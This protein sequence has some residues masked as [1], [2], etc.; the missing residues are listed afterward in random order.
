MSKSEHQQQ[1][2]SHRKRD[3]VFSIVGGILVTVQLF[4]SMLLVFSL[5]KLNILQAWQ[6]A[7][8]IIILAL[9]LAY[10]VFELVFR[11]R[12]KTFG[13]VASCILAALIAGGC[14]YAYTYIQQAN[15]FISEITTVREET[16]M[17]EVRI[18]KD[19][20]I[21]DIKELKDQP[22]GFLKTSPNLDSI[23]TTLKDQLGS[24]Q[25]VDYDEVGLMLMD[26]YDNK[27]AAI[28]LN[29][30][31][32]SFLEDTEY[33]LAETTT[34]IHD[35]R[36]S[37]PN[38]ADLRT[39]VNVVEEPF[40]LYISGSD[41]RGTINTASNSDVNI[42]TVV[43]PAKGKI[44]LVNIARDYYVQ[45]HGTTGL[46]DKL[47]HAGIYGIDMSKSTIEDLLG[48]QI[49]Y[50]FKVGFQGVKKF[51]DAIDGIDV[52]SRITKN[53]SN[54]DGKMCYIKQGWNH[55][56]GDCA[57]RYARERKSY[58]YGDLDRGKNQQQVIT[59]IINKLTDLHY[60]TR[61]TQILEAG[62]GTFQTSLTDTEITNFVKW[63]LAELKKWQVESIQ[64]EGTASMEPTYTF[65][66]RT[67]LYVF[68]PSEASEAAAKEKIAE[69]LTK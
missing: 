31:Y 60:L 36:V 69:Y 63:Q 20:G 7:L 19:S 15:D 52:E 45:L 39:P 57:L 48:I 1:H 10:N 47:T 32:L 18:N 11:K 5:I 29:E 8:V 55:L 13:K 67:K 56:D 34:S 41:S 43:N 2:H 23:K 16:I 26:F 33:N 66:A 24:Y 51:V 42:L 37:N 21:K 62:K 35:I 17:Y 12:A 9:I 4:A 30:S 53:M 54:E 61:Y 6:L 3:L 22:I 27:L 28:V 25:D 38:Q 14:I 68:L 50:T 44:L 46:K 59:A 40:I 49:N 65:G 64:I 58:K